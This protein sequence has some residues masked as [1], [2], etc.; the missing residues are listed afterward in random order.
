MAF[1]E[2]K[3]HPLVSKRLEAIDIIASVRR[4]ERQ[5]QLLDRADDDLVGPVIGEESAHEGFGVGVFL[6][7][8]LLEAVEFFACLAVE[9]LAVNDEQALFNIWVGLQ[10][11]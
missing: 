4:I 8:A 11:R 2:D 7:A 9:I 1:V 3:N 5:A 6:D 10:E